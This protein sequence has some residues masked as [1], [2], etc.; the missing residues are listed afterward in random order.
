M[1]TLE[2][3]YQ[4]MQ[5]YEEFDTAHEFCCILGRLAR[6]EQQGLLT[7]DMLVQFEEAV[8]D[9]WQKVL[10][11]FHFLD[12]FTLIL[13]KAEQAGIDATH[14]CTLSSES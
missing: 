14:S 12:S 9:S 8:L 3:A 5:D 2:E 11:V 1:A 4:W 6:L 7:R 10:S 13:D